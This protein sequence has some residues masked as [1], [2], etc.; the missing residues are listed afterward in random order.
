MT[1]VK[2]KRRKTQKLTICINFHGRKRKP[3][4]F[5]GHLY[6]NGVLE[7]SAIKQHFRD[8]K[9]CRDHFHQVV[10]CDIGL[11]TLRVDLYSKLLEWHNCRSM[12][13]SKPSF[14]SDQLGLTCISSI[15]DYNSRLDH[16]V[17]YGQLSQSLVESTLNRD[18]AKFQVD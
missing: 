17:M 14:T 15:N 6:N 13:G 7:S 5:K 10:T 18:C 4:A 2:T 3:K 9:F 12:G 1:K 8:Q 16:Q 11:A